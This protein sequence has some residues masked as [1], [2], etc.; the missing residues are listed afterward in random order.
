MKVINN[1]KSNSR[2]HSLLPR[3]NEWLNKGVDL[4]LLAQRIE[5]FF[6]EDGFTDVM[7]QQDQVSQ[8]WEIQARKTDV[9]RTLVGSRKAIH[10]IIRGNP[11]K[12]QIIMDVG[13]WGK[14][15]AAGAILAVFT[16]GIGLIGVGLTAEFQHKLWNRIQE[17]VDS[18]TSTSISPSVQTP[19]TNQGSEA[20]SLSQPTTL[21]PTTPP[22]VITSSDPAPQSSSL[23]SSSGQDDSV[24]RKFCYQCGT[25][26]PKNA[27]YCSTCGIEQN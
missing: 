11:N 5:K 20:S 1:L 6:R 14:N 18:L 3:Q 8:W 10:V 24:P 4:K 25:Q 23:A 16:G 13:D 7:I 12:F 27:R 2:H 15:I 9:M 26:I 21:P 17:A 19:Q 22:A